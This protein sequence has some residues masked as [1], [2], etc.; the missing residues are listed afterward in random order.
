M[1]MSMICILLRETYGKVIYNIQEEVCN[2]AKGCTFCK[3]CVSRIGATKIC[4][5]FQNT[6]LK[7]YKSRRGAH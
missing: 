5:Y 6:S 4:F 2:N 3:S 7:T 1:E